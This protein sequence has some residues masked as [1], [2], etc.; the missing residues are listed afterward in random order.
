M[1]HMTA[2]FRVLTLAMA[3][4]M[5]LTSLPLVPVQAAMVTTDQVITQSEIEADRERVRAFLG[6]AEVQRE[7]QA[8]GINPA[9]AA[10]RV[11]TL[12]DA[13]VQ[14]IAG[15]LDQLPAGQN[16]VGAIIGAAVLIFLVLLVTDLLGLTDVFPFVKKNQ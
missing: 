13:E 16:A 14:Q 2:R 15:R 11:S 10:E 6:R 5:A 9:E 4:I 3:F 1:Q 12:S 8:L 7:L